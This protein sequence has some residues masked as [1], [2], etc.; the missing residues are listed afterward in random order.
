VCPAIENPG[1]AL[2]RSPATALLDEGRA[3]LKQGRSAE[4]LVRFEAACQADPRCAPARSD[5]LTEAIT[6]AWANPQDLQ[7]PAFSLIRLDQR[8]ARC[9][10]LANDS[11]PARPSRG[12]L[13]GPDGLAA[14]SD[15]RL[16]HALLE[17]A[18]VRSV[19]VERFLTCARRALLEI[20]AH[21]EAPLAAEMAALRFFAALARQCFT[22]EYVF[23]CAGEEP[24]AAAEC[25]TR[26]VALLD[27][28]AAVPPFV[29]LAV[30]AYFPLHE[31]PEPQRL[32]AASAPGP[33]NEVLRQQVREPLEEQVLRAGIES[34]TSIAAGVS[35]AVREQYEESPYP[36]WVK[37]PRRAQPLPLNI[38]LRNTL[39]FARFAALPDDSAPQA[40]VAG[41]GTGSDAILVAERFRGVRVLAI[42]L[43]LSSLAYAKRK[44]LELGVTNI[45]Y[46]QADILRLGGLERSFDVIGAVGVLHH[47]ADPFAG[48]RVLLSRLRPRGLMCLGLYSEIARRPV[49]KAREFIAAHG[50]ENTPQGVRRFRQAVLAGD[51]DSE[52]QSLGN[53][54]A[55]YSLS[56]CRDLAFHVQEQ[57]LTLG[58]I[59]SFI[60]EQGLKFVG[61]ELDLRVLDQYRARFRDD[62]HCAS[63][64]NWARF[65]TDHPRTF[66]AMY[67]FW[68]Q[69]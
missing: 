25:R 10:S 12:A 51:A 56:D 64:A 15:N 20:A 30:A 52:L 19:R 29:M 8:I 33:L 49:V 47:L 34:L 61:F 46:A 28:G 26:L 65:E 58:Q 11:W 16:L 41:C 3:L 35:A 50:F 67:R 40:L 9:V 53:S 14:L 21:E 38:E 4:A 39:P 22:N 69:K 44:S 68:I 43:S 48:W 5:A 27:A 37:M 31:L 59:E 45:E 24:H 23:E 63:L 55:F 54:R 62:P 36:R 32:L 7:G 17:A 66:T 1:D 6:E 60:G 42:D 13:F 2:P 57:H 18:P